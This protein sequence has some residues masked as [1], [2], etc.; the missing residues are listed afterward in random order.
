MIDKQN[1]K[2]IIGERQEELLSIQIVERPMQF[3]RSSNYVLIGPRR[4]G[5]SYMLYWY[6]PTSKMNV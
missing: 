2:Q 3:D 1:I 6:I 5:K 4:A